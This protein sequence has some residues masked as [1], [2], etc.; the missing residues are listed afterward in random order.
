VK[1]YTQD[2]KARG[3]TI[4]FH[5][6]PVEPRRQPLLDRG[7]P[8]P[9]VNHLVTMGELHRAGRHDR[10]SD[11]VRMLTGKNRWPCRSCV[12]IW[13]M[14]TGTLSDAWQRALRHLTDAPL[15]EASAQVPRHPL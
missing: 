2:H 10:V 15:F 12:R 7:L 5:D 14:Y 13:I 1:R 9:L 4:S 3:R 11:D 6:I 8:V